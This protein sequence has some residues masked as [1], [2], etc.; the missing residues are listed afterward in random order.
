M[1]HW[2]IRKQ[3]G[4]GR[5]NEEEKH[6]LEEILF[7]PG[8]SYS[9]INNKNVMYLNGINKRVMGKGIRTGRIIQDFQVEGD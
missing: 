2:C 1:A 4:S 5:D 9:P 6:I 3:G 8:A 7:N